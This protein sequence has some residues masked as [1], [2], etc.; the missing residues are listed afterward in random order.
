M[1]GRGGYAVVWG[2]VFLACMLLAAVFPQV[3]E[4]APEFAQR[5]WLARFLAAELNRGVVGGVG[6]ERLVESI[7]DGAANGI[8]Q[9][10]V[11]DP[12]ENCWYLPGWIDNTQTGSWRVA[13]L[14][15][16]VS[17]HGKPH[18]W[19]FYLRCEGVVPFDQPPIEMEGGWRGEDNGVR[20][21]WFDQ[22]LGKGAGKDVQI[23]QIERQKM[24]HTSI[25]GDGR[26]GASY[27]DS[28]KGGCQIAFIR[29]SPGYSRESIDGGTRN[30][31][32]TGER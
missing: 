5:E 9:S 27:A 12:L 23:V 22:S 32:V 28:G 19:R 16:A 21:V 30:A 20:L 4:P 14:L 15:S 2:G 13:L 25:D 7:A 3:A 31:L 10:A 17:G 29:H 11:F 24:P 6:L 26:K 8:W 18:A 1:M